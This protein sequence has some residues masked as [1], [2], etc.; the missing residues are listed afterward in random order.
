MI[1]ATEAKKLTRPWSAESIP[2]LLQHIERRILAAT[3]KYEYH[4]YI[5]Y[6][7]K[8]DKELKEELQR[9][10]YIFADALWFNSFSAHNELRIEW[11]K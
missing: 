5:R 4:L 7:A 2:E 10:G 6:P 11:Y 8:F 9:L 1:S 3:L